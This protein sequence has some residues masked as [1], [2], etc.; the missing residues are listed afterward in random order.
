M[1]KMNQARKEKFNDECA[2]LFKKAIYHRGSYD[3]KLVYENTIKA[4]KQAIDKKAPFELDVQLTNDLQVVCLHDTNLKRFFNRERDVKDISYK[5]LNKLRDD[6][7]VPLLKDVLKLVDGKVELIIELKSVNRKYN[8][9]LVKRVYE[10]LKDYNGKYVIV[11]FNPFMLG[12]YRRLDKRAYLGRNGTS[13]TAN[14][15]EKLIVDKNYFNFLAKPDFISY[16][17]DNFNEE[18]LLKYKEK[19]YKIIGWTL[20]DS[21]RKKELKKHYDNFIVENL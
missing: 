10:L 3:N 17:V 6:L 2:W 13:N 19:G 4:Y 7:Q 8:K 18:R 1:S 14:F 11:S 9:E 15:I 21:N 12:S 20:K 5:R 16:D